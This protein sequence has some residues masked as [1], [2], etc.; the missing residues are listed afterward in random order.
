MHGSNVAGLFA[1]A[2]IFVLALGMC[3]LSAAQA[4]AQTLVVLDVP[5]GVITITPAWD[6]FATGRDFVRGGSLESRKSH[7]A[8]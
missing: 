2:K 4:T 6:A 7:R 3:V 5:G 8:E 1:A